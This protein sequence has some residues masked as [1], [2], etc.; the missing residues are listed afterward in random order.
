MLTVLIVNSVAS[1]ML[2]FT[3]ASGLSIIFGIL[4]SFWLSVIISS[5]FVGLI[6]GLVERIF[7]RHIYG[8][9]EVYQ[10]LLTYTL[11]LIIDGIARVVWGVDVK[12]VQGSSFLSGRS[13]FFGVV[14]PTYSLV[15]IGIGAA[16]MAGLW[17]FIEKSGPGKLIRAAA[18]DREITQSLGI[19]VP[20]IFFWTFV[21]GAWLAGFG[22][23]LATMNQV[24]SLAMAGTIIVECFA[25]VVIGGLGSLKGSIVGSLLVGF[26][27]SFGPYYFPLFG[28]CFLYF[29]MAVVLI[30][31]PTGLFG[32]SQR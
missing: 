21:G 14:Y 11:V 28:M 19:N 5:T 4:G 23:A 12:S 31:K 18:E 2:L 15:I 13:E 22:G 20:K 16:L 7:L 1:G 8:V 3:V 30:I 17:I 32:F 29:L 10:L 25:V 6:G 9:S 27:I 24:I 26:V